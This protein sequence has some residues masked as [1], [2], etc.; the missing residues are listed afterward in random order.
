MAWMKE[1]SRRVEE[2]DADMIWAGHPGLRE[3]MG[4]VLQ[5]ERVNNRFGCL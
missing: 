2:D 3:S 1:A 5:L 4:D